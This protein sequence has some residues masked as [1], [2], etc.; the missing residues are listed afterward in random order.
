MTIKN[1]Q[2]T[3]ETRYEDD[4]NESPYVGR[5]AKSSSILKLQIQIPNGQ[6]VYEIPISSDLRMSIEKASELQ[7]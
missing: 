3:T 5:N 1:V 2:I 4:D 6:A 7:K